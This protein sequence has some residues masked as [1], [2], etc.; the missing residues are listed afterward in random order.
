M[1][2][3]YIFVRF[4]HSI[5]PF[6]EQFQQVS[7]F[8][9]HRWIHSISTIYILIPPSSFPPPT[10]IH[11]QKRFIF[12]SC[13]SFLKIKCILIVQ[14]GFALVLQLCT[15]RAFIKLT[16]PLCNLLILYHRA[17]LI[18]DSLLYSALYYIHICMDV[19]IFFIL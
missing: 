6:L 4:T 9:F 13:P 19:S 17:P 7:F 8:Y 16:P 3:Q 11:P 18:V 14:G 15:Y 10:G 12:P 5:L 1:C 2:L